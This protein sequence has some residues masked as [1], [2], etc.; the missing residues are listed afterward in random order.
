MVAHHV[1]L[2]RK[3]KCPDCKDPQPLRAFGRNRASKDGLHYYCKK[4]AAKRQK[5]WAKDN[6][7]KVKSMRASYTKKV[8]DQNA[9]R[10]P[11]EV[12]A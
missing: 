4:C 7:D 8:H 2:T 12:A 10:D 1:I 3:K 11:Y 5:K 9:E 6:P